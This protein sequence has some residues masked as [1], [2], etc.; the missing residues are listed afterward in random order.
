MKR[1]GGFVFVNWLAC[2]VY[3]D[4]ALALGVCCERLL[5]E[6]AEPDASVILILTQ[7]VKRE[8]SGSKLKDMPPTPQP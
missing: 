2:T 6:T 8:V 5:Y 1:T 3:M 4:I 7:S